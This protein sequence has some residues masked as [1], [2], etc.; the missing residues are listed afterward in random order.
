MTEEEKDK[1]PEVIRERDKQ[2]EMQILAKRKRDEDRQAK[3][4]K[5]EEIK[6]KR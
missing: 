6:S 5:I 4:D 3:K 1:L 2:K